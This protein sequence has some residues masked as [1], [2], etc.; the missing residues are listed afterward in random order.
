M[1]KEIDYD[2]DYQE[3][4]AHTRYQKAKQRT[5]LDYPSK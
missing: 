5:L 2:T 1:Q 3:S 4:G